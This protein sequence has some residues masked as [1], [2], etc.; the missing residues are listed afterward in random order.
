MN[1]IIANKS[2][3]QVSVRSDTSKSQNKIEVHRQKARAIVQDAS[4]KRKTFE[5]ESLAKLATWQARV[6]VVVSEDIQLLKQ[7]FSGKTMSDE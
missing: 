4:E 2:R 1:S 5:K 3:M 7:I 6:K